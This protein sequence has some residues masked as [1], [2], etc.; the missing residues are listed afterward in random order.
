MAT[1]AEID[2]QTLPMGAIGFMA[3]TIRGAEQMGSR[4]GIQ[5]EL[6]PVG[7]GGGDG[8]G[9]S[10]GGDGGGDGCGGVGGVGGGDGDGGE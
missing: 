1:Y 8:D 3:H 9:G 10:G 6:P 7:N 2:H 4:Y 5:R